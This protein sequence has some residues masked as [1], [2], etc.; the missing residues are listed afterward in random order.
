VGSHEVAE[1]LFGDRKHRRIYISSKATTSPFFRIGANIC[2][3]K[4][5]LLEWIST[6]EEKNAKEWICALWLNAA[7]ASGAV[8]TASGRDGELP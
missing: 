1:F 4:S 5:I 7:K 3:C 8:I 6:Q 2:A